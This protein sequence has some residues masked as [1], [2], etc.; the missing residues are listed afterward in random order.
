MFRVEISEKRMTHSGV[1]WLLHFSARHHP[2][3]R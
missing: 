2:H 1:I 3:K